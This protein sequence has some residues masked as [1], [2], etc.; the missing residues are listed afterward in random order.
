MTWHP[1]NGP[2]VKPSSGS[3]QLLE[4]PVMGPSSRQRELLGVPCLLSQ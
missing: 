1:T 4:R 2:T 3:T